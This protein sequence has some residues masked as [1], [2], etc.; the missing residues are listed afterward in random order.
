MRDRR[1][2]P[3]SLF[4]L[5]LVAL[6]TPVSAAAQGQDTLV[7]DPFTGTPGTSLASHAPSVNVMG[8]PWTIGGNPSIAI[9]SS[10]GAVRPTGSGG[11]V[12]GT[13]DSGASDVQVVT[14][15]SPSQ[16]A[17]YPNSGIVFRYVNSTNY[18]YAYFFNGYVYLEKRAPEWRR[19]HVLGS[20]FVF[21]WLMAHAAG[22]CVWV[23]HQSLL[24]LFNRP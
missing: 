4:L 8:G 20:S 15:W 17:S 5:L 16:W 12:Y 11:P 2:S 1:S 10:G 21:S 7:F 22:V 23:E 3:V 19:L 6:L 14:S 9:D 18:L 24:G 13:I